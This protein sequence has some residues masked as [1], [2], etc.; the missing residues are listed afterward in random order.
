MLGD[1]R[2]EISAHCV[3]AVTAFLPFGSMRISVTQRSSQTAANWR[4][5]AGRSA[6]VRSA[7]ILGAHSQP[8]RLGVYKCKHDGA[9]VASLGRFTYPNNRSKSF[10]FRSPGGWHR[11]HYRHSNMFGTERGHVIIC[12]EIV[13]ASSAHSRNNDRTI[14]LRIAADSAVCRTHTHTHTVIHHRMRAR[15]RER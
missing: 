7:S 9:R 10:V 6:S 13:L 14:R 11:A 15:T 8:H 5:L 4:R 12:F 1:R 3:D 2:V